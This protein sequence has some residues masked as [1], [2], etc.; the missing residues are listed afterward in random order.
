MIDAQNAAR[1]ALSANMSGVAAPAVVVPPPP[2]PP[3]AE[4]PQDVPPPPVAEPPPHQA[5][6]PTEEPEGRPPPV[7]AESLIS[8]INSLKPETIRALEMEGWTREQPVTQELLD[9]LGSRY[10][11]FNNRAAE[12]ARRLKGDGDG[13]KPPQTEGQ[14]PVPVTSQEQLEQ[15]LGQRI[16]QDQECVS[17]VGEYQANARSRETLSQSVATAEK[18]IERVV[19]RLG[20]PEVKE[21]EFRAKEL[22]EQLRQ[23]RSDLLH[24]QLQMDRIDAKNDR[25]DGKF[26]QR[27]DQHADEIRR[28]VLQAERKASEDAEINGYASEFSTKV[29]DAVSR[30]AAEFGFRDPGLVE[31]LHQ[32]VRMEGLQRVSSEDGEAIE[33][34]DGFVRQVA[35]KRKSRMEA[36]HRDQSALYAARQREKAAQVAPNPPTHAVTPPATPASTSADPLEDIYKRARAE[37]AAALRG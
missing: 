7:A 4:P 22:T 26:R 28:Q 27:R 29:G 3:P 11:E 25:L 1:A 23:H 18:E 35:E 16:K 20:Y 8:D 19:D 6:P 9:R 24:A 14:P 21:D 32:A 34:V 12:L 31:D 2:E 17:W 30:V 13:G 10:V 5:E 36:Y 37:S 33:D 15:E